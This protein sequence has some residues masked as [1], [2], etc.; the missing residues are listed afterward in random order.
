VRD[1]APAAG[2]RLDHASIEVPDLREAIERFDRLGLDVTVSPAAS[3]RHGRL[4]LHR[5]YLEIAADVGVASWR[6]SL[7]FLGFPDRARLV[8]HLDEVG[9]T[10]RYGTYEGVDGTWDDV[11][12][13]VG[14]VSA[15]LLVR[16]TE[17]AEVAR[18]WPPPLRQPHRCGATMLAAVHLPAASLEPA[19]EVHARLLGYGPR[20]GD[21]GDGTAHHR[22]ATFDLGTGSLVL[23][24]G[25]AGPGVVLGVTSLG[26]ANEILGRPLAV[27]DGGIAW[28]D[29]TLTSGLRIGFTDAGSVPGG[30]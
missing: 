5:T 8:A 15:P 26:R 11:E 28:L 12:L 18:D 25:A 30:R 2:L 22:R 23:D 1:Q 3:D 20:P 17:P 4:H 9:L 13:L 6:V 27:D 14:D 24:E 7:V 10:Y 19:V 16:R 29:P 21:G